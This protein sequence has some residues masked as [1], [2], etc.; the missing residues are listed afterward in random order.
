MSNII[1]NLNRLPVNTWEWLRINSTSAEI[2]G[3]MEGCAIEPD[4]T[5]PDGVS[6]YSS[7]NPIT[8]NLP[9]TVKEAGEF[10]DSLAS[11]RDIIVISTKTQEPIEAKYTLKSREKGFARLH[12]SAEAGS[13]ATVVIRLESED[14]TDEALAFFLSVEVEKDAK[15]K[16]IVSQLLKRKCFYLGAIT[17]TVAGAMDVTIVELG[18]ARAISG[19][20]I[21][22]DGEE[23]VSN[24]NAIYAAGGEDKRDLNY[25]LVYNAPKTEGNIKVRGVLS[26]K[27]QKTFKSTIDFIS[28]ASESKG[29][30]E[31]Y[32]LVLSDKV[33]NIS[34]P[35]LLCGEDNVQGEHATNIGRPDE[36]KVY[37]L[38]TRGFSELEAKKILVEAAFAPIIAEIPNETLRNQINE[39]IEE[40]T[41]YGI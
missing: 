38:M 14:N 16:I 35:L 40:V 3:L 27:A 19:C 39:R 32:V 13:E 17:G 2:D 36:A 21:I 28:G 25:R 9:K 29:R 4:I 10:V 20:D 18:G 1:G 30:E 33:R 12:I 15:I 22:L 41:E 26:E 24:I 23:A 5:A 37:Y 6:V 8:E 11:V 31:E 34:T 7:E